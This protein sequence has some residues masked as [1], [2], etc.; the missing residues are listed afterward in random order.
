MLKTENREEWIPV[1]TSEGSNK[2][3]VLLTFA[4]D[5]EAGNYTLECKNIKDISME[6]NELEESSTLTV[7]SESETEVMT[8][9]AEESLLQAHGIQVGIP[10]VLVL[11]AVF[12]LIH[13]KKSKKK[14]EKAAEA[15]QQ[16]VSDQT[17]TVFD[18]GSMAERKTIVFQIK[19]RGDE[20]RMTIKNSMIIGRSKSC[21]L[22]FNDPTMSRQ[23]F[24]L[25]V[26]NGKI[27]ILNLSKS[28][29]T[30][31]NDMKLADMEQTLHSGD[32]IRAG[33]TELMI[34]WE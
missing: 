7:E 1:Y 8:E 3:S 30:M 25:T 6:E 5:L 4:D 12:W 31:V 14:K 20:V 22:S 16:P 33:Q 24:A 18:Q 19:G 26:K 13:R 21:N 29:Y 17:Q 11:A 34:K 2:E 32:R 28:S 10:A 15:V 27:M 23:H 9:Q